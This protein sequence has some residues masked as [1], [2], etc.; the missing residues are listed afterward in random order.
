MSYVRLLLTLAGLYASPLRAAEGDGARH[1]YGA[2]G[3][4]LVVEALRDDVVHFELSA[5]GAGDAGKAIYTT[6]MVAKTDYPGPSTLAADD[7]HLETAL[8]DVAVDGALCVTVRD[9]AHAALLQTVCPLDLDQ[10]WK[11]LSISSPGTRNVYGLG[12]YFGDTNMD[13]DWSSRLWDP[14]TDGFGNRLRGFSG[15]ANDYSMFPIMYALGDGVQGYAF[16]F[17]QLYKQQWDFRSSPWR[18]YTWGDQLRWYVLAGGDLPSLRRSYME[19]TGRPP[20]PPKRSFGLWVSEF[21]FLNWDEVEASLASLRQSHFP[22]EGFAMDLQWFGGTFGDPDHSKMGTLTWDERSFPDPK[23]EIAKLAGEG[24]N[25]MTIEEPYVSN[26]LPEYTALAGQGALALDCQGCAPTYLNYNPWWGRGGMLDFTAPAAGDY[27]HDYRRQLLVEM[28]INDH[29]A[30]LGEPEQYNANAWYLGF[31]ELGKHAHADIHNIYGFDWMAS[32]YRGYQRHHNPRRPYLLSRTG[33][34]GIQRFG[35]GMWSGDIGTNWGNLASQMHAQMHMSL[36]GVDYYGSDVGGFQRSQGGVAGGTELLYT[37]WFAASSLLD[38]PVRPHAWNLDKKRP[39]APSLRGDAASNLDNLRW[40]YRLAPYYYSLA[41]AA[42]L[43][44]EPV[45]PPLVY[46]FQSDPNVRQLGSEKM[47]GPSLLAAVVADP[48]AVSRSLYLPAGDWVDFRT[49]AWVESAGLELADWP[50]YD[51]GTFRLPLFARAGAIVPMA[52]VDDQTQNI[53]GRRADG[54][55]AT[56]LTVRVA[57]GT[58]RTAFELYD[59]DGETFGYESGRFIKTHLE[60]Q[61]TGGHAEVLVAAVQ[62][63]FDGMAEQRPL[64]IEL[65]VRDREATGATVDGIALRP[66]ARVK[67]K[68][69]VEAPCYKNAGHGIIQVS[70]GERSVRVPTVVGVDLRQVAAPAPSLLLICRNGATTPGTSIYAVGDSDRLGA[71]QPAKGLKL[72][73]TAYPTWTTRLDDLPAAAKIA[74]KC[75]RQKDDMSGTPEWQPG[76]NNVAV[77]PASGYGGASTGAFAASASEKRTDGKD[78]R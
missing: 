61:L 17:D 36:S 6:P 51:A 5:V 55:P 19:L 52:V 1:L 3:R 18:V 2:P 23:G 7:H 8:L 74:W 63:A 37:Q 71:W 60:Q 44:G 31:P 20:V 62:G 77:T 40:R 50:L 66:C 22:V 53:R 43:S 70:A 46:Y 34:S 12:Q 42:H 14:L 4:Y 45:A 58:E 33:T 28:G 39:T 10:A 13:G 47:L 72:A 41:F 64:T 56:A 75:V 29:W 15:G 68:A 38:T 49:G 16:F 73:P 25:I 69:K 78:R 35:V 48:E 32:V 26:L 76:A 59:D 24:V 9:K 57:A 27:W 67:A 21:G 65:L 11:G 30:D 54:Q